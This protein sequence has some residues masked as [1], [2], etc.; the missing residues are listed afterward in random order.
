MLLFP[1][2]EIIPQMLFEND[3]TRKKRSHSDDSNQ[4]LK[5]SRR[6]KDLSSLDQ[7]TPPINLSQSYQSH[8]P[9]FWFHNPL[10]YSR[11]NDTESLSSPFTR[12]KDDS[13]LNF[14]SFYLALNRTS[15]N[16]FERKP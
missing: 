13:C 3:I 12:S 2:E 7:S 14:K 5:R 6:L 15:S 4:T 9:S 16:E 11:N 10:E 1:Q 8:E